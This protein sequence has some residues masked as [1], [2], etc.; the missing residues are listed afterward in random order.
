[1]H[2]S[3][4]RL[5]LTTAAC[6]ALGACTDSET[7]VVP[8][9][10]VQANGAPLEYD[11][12]EIFGDVYVNGAALS[13]NGYYVMLEPSQ[14]T[15]AKITALGYAD[16]DSVMAVRPQG[17]ESG[18]WMWGWYDI[19]SYQAGCV[20]APAEVHWRDFSNPP[21]S[22]RERHCVTAGSY[23][24]SIWQG[25]PEAGGTK[26][27]T[28]EV[29][30]IGSH[31]T[32]DLLSGQWDHE[33]PQ[34]AVLIY[35]ANSGRT[36]DVMEAGPGTMH[37]AITDLIIPIDIGAA[38]ASQYTISP[39][40]RIDSIGWTIDNTD[41][42]FINDS[43]PRGD[44][45]TYFRF[46]AS[47][48]TAAG[49][50]LKGRVTPLARLSFDADNSIH[51]TPFYDYHPNDG[52]LRT[53]SYNRQVDG[54]DTSGVRRVNLEILNPGD[55]TVAPS[56]SISREVTVSMVG[57]PPQ[58]KACM[59]YEGSQAVW[60]LSA[61]HFD[62]SCSEDNAGA[63]Y[64]WR[65]GDTAAYTAWSSG[66]GYDFAGWNTAGSKT[67]RLEMKTQL[68]TVYT[69]TEF[70]VVSSY[71]QLS[72][73]TYIREK[74]TYLYQSTESGDWYERQAAIWER[75]PWWVASDT[76]RRVWSAGEYDVD[77]RQQ[78]YTVS[79]NAF[80]RAGMN[81]QVC[82]GC[83]YGQRV[84]GV[85]AKDSLMS[86]FGAG[87]MIAV[88]G[89]LSSFY[90][91]ARGGAPNTDFV[92]P[93]WLQASSTAKVGAARLRDGRVQM[94]WAI[95]TQPGRRRIDLDLYGTG[96][97]EVRFGFAW[98][99]DVGSNA[100]DDHSGYDGEL[101]MVYAFDSGEAVG[102]LIERDG[103]RT[104]LGV[105]QYGSKRFAPMSEARLLNDLGS[106]S[107]NLMD[108]PDDVQFIVSAGASTHNTHYIIHLVR[109]PDL[110]TLRQRARTVD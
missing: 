44:Q 62:A 50:A 71:I 20:D 87:P 13:S 101:G 41:N 40:L 73:P 33:K 43:M 110:A 23:T 81:I 15:R 59:S 78:F 77:L 32:A 51:T 36:G 65:F 94:E 108:G 37:P 4:S 56:D 58:P 46:D 106:A 18:G 92:T 66:P 85:A 24:I 68:D 35:N 67:V 98:D 14:P 76:M 95:T 19:N 42:T 86:T 22:S 82:T 27:R 21:S 99:P 61:Q 100:A 93:Q 30:Y 45:Y 6:L 49:G 5:V 79:N 83:G 91:L 9:L 10:P 16:F 107:L 104:K 8:P 12:E 47:G 90:D 55:A 80:A 54:A 3:I 17:H 89:E 103:V 52:L 74:S 39:V 34:P 11:E 69:E 2:T 7:T 1:M 96:T 64:R 105:H 26:L 29:E 48:T 70:Q 75:N 38:G 102:L 31:P 53:F 109:A 88:D 63:Q 25:S 97:R 28:I 72:G 57:P 84:V 60:R